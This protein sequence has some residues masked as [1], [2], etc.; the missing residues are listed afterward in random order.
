MVAFKQPMCRWY[1]KN[2]ADTDL[3]GH[4]NLLL[5]TM[6]ISELEIDASNLERFSKPK[7]LC[8][9][10]LTEGASPLK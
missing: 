1:R 3:V 8:N 5:P 7:S 10:C 9:L 4:R 2:S 6:S